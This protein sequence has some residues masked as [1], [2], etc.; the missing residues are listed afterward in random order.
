[1][2]KITGNRRRL[3]SVVVIVLLTIAVVTWLLSKTG[4]FMPA[5]VTSSN[6]SHYQVEIPVTME[7]SR[8]N[9]NASLEYADENSELYAVVIDE[10]KAKIISFGLDYDLETYMKIAG[11]ALDSTGLYLNKSIKVGNFNA[12][13]TEIKANFRNKKVVYLLTCIETPK[14]FYQVLVWTLDDRYEGNKADME[15]MINSFK[16]FDK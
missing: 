10:S 15:R 12:L 16:E 7:P 14:H 4:G 11:R 2:K 13:Q 5:D 9:E 1:M 6:G 8:L 3:I